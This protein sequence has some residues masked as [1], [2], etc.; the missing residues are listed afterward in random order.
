MSKRLVAI[1]SAGLVLV[2]TL[3]AA[4]DAASRRSKPRAWEHETSDL[5]VNPV[6]RF[7]TLDNGVRFA[8]VKNAEPKQRC[9]LRIHFD[10]GSLAEDESERGM[11]HFLEHM[12]FNGSTNFPPGTLVEWLQRRGLD[13]VCA[14]VCAPKSRPRRST[15]SICRRRTRSSS[16][17]V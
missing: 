12:S 9:Y 8:W 6:I 11:A 7:G 3:H 17:K 4:D 14:L 2:S 5:P 13:F 10:V 16:A 15:C 1:L